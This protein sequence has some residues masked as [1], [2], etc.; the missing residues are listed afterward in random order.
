MYGMV[1]ALVVQPPGALVIPTDT[2]LITAARAAGSTAFA[3]RIPELDVISAP[4]IA[5][6]PRPGPRLPG[7][8]L[9]QRLLLATDLSPSA[10]PAT[11]WA[12]DLALLTGA[13]LIILSVIEPHD[14]R[15]PGRPTGVRVDQVRGHRETAALALVERGQRMGVPVSFLIWSGDPGES[16]GPVLGPKERGGLGVLCGSCLGSAPPYTRGRPGT[17]VTNGRKARP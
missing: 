10:Q 3:C 4:V 11:E 14:R 1:T 8:T 15:L 12:L 16:G 17:P 13:P 5:A 7:S 9:P 2:P 6:T